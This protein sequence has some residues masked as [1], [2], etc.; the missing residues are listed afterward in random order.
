MCV[1][2]AKLTQLLSAVAY[3]GRAALWW[4]EAAAAALLPTAFV[5]QNF[6]C[7]AP[8]SNAEKLYEQLSVRAGKAAA[9]GVKLTPV[10]L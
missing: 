1:D 7:L 4:R 3:L 10:K 5:C 8:T 6:T 9:G 2:A